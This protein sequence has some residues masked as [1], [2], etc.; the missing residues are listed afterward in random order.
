MH[1]LCVAM[2]LAS[3]ELGHNR[4]EHS[5]HFLSR[6]HQRPLPVAMPWIEFHT[7]GPA[8]ECATVA[9]MQ[10]VSGKGDRTQVGRVLLLQASCTRL[11]LWHVP[12]S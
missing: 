7:T 11:T 2:A 8:S 3:S 1:K 12:L 5:E 4:P 9:F 6:V 10:R